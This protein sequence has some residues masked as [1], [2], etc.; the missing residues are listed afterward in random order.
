MGQ[1]SVSDAGITQGALSVS[2]SGAATYQ[3]PIAVPPGI[4]DIAPAISLNYNSQSGNGIA[5]WGWN[6]GGLSTITRIPS[7]L[8]HDGVV[9][10]VDFD[11]TD[12][13]AL[14]GQRLLLKSGTYGANNAAYE[15]ENYSNTKK[16]S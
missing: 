11:A 14:D 16:I 8:F 9:D 2:L 4:R 5:G 7:T 15:T 6:I 1:Q 13:Y 12:R 3:V 10:P